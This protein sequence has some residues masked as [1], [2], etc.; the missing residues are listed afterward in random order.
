MNTAP[1]FKMPRGGITSTGFAAVAVGIAQGFLADYVRY[2][3][4]RKSRGTAV[5]D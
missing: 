5:A 3:R 1:V 2:T 4:T